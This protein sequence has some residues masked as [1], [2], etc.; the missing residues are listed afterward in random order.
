MWVW[1]EVDCP[2]E[3]RSPSR[4]RLGPT[5]RESRGHLA[6]SASAK[7]NDRRLSYRLEKQKVPAKKT[8]SIL[9]WHGWS[10]RLLV[11]LLAPAMVIST[12][13]CVP[14]PRTVAAPI[15]EGKA[16]LERTISREGAI[17]V[18]SEE[19]GPTTL[20]DGIRVVSCE[21]SLHVPSPG[22]ES[23]VRGFRN[24]VEHEVARAGGTVYGKTSGQC[25]SGEITKFAVEAKLGAARTLVDVRTRWTSGIDG[26][27][28]LFLTLVQ[29]DVP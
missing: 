8:V 16:I 13:G 15:V 28:Q 12:T 4:R 2:E 26:E 29:I 3:L 18:Q 20:K 25:D 24:R 19:H 22:M 10:I 9:A 1:E 6:G 21:F 27:T 7:T 14:Q 23:F 11:V 5:V 17:V